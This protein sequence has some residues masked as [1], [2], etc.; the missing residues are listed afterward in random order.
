MKIFKKTINLINLEEIYI[1]YRKLRI[2]S[3]Y[4]TG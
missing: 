1:E 4:S 3:E 2:H